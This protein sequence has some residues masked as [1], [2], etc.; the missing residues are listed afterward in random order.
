MRRAPVSPAGVPD[1]IAE[2]KGFEPLPRR[3]EVAAGVLTCPGQIT[4]LSDRRVMR[5]YGLNG[6]G[7]GA[8]GQNVLIA[9]DGGERVLAGKASAWV[10]AGTTI[11]VRTPGGGGWGEV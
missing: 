11:S 7:S 8:P 2:Q 6:G 9:A 10:E 5:P 1:V 3:F 4:I